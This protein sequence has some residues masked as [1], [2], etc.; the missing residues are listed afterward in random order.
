MRSP[1]LPS[2][3]EMPAKI[4]TTA[5]VGN[6]DTN[7]KA[8]LAVGGLGAIIGIISAALGQWAG[9]GAGIC[10]LLAGVLSARLGAPAK[11]ATATATAPSLARIVTGQ[12]PAP[13]DRPDKAESKSEV[14]VN[15]PDSGLF[16]EQ[17]FHVMVE[18]RVA[19]AKR[20]LRPVAVVL[21]NVS[22][23]RTLA[24][25]SD[26]QGVSRVIRHTL[27]DADTAC[28]LDDGRFGF[29]L[30][31]TPEDGAVWTLERLRRALGEL[32]PSLVQW[33]GVACYPAHAFNAP[34]V[35]AKAEQALKAAKEWTQTR[36]EVATPS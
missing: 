13:V 17:Y 23:G 9:L 30:E 19:A 11:V 4:E 28:H 20:H 31:D 1:R 27:R 3:I 2:N 26:I 32:D 35:L 14:T 21:V 22:D 18:T 15:H 5:D 12:T 25:A 7:Q 29:V 16:N 8:A 10:A 24:A 36:I 33:A 6:L 34:E